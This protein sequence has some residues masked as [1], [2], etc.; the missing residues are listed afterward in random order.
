MVAALPMITRL[1][2][3]L[4]LD[5]TALVEGHPGLSM[6]VNSPSYNLF[7]VPEAV[8]S[9]HIPNQ[10]FVTE[11]GIRSVIGFGGLLPSQEM[12]A[13]ILFCRNYVARERALLF[14]S[15]TLNT[16]IAILPADHS[17]VVYAAAV[18]LPCQKTGDSPPALLQAENETLRLLLEAQESAVVV[19]TDHMNRAQ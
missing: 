12:F 17:G 9:P 6:E 19:Q 16:Q 4:G 14:R 11:N 7:Y 18:G 8:G 5:M 2:H 15:L 1:L 3:Q 10:E 13:T